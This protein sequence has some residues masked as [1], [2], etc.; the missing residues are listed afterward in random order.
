MARIA[1]TCSHRFVDADRCG[2][3]R[4]HGED[5]CYYHLRYSKSNNPTD[6]DYELPLLEDKDSVQV[7]VRDIMV[8]IL[9]GDI[10]SRKAHLLLYATQIASNNIS[11]WQKIQH[12]DDEIE[13]EP[14]EPKEPIMA[15]ILRE[16]LA[17]LTVHGGPYHGLPAHEVILGKMDESTLEPK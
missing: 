15:K 12:Q 3:R 1:R 14:E 7:V 9:K 16:G 11:R 2:A 6:A 4:L 8:G 13:E 17:G 5:Y 10:D